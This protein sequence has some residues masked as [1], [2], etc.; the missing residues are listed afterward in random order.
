MRAIA[1]GAPCSVTQ[2]LPAASAAMPVGLLVDRGNSLTTPPVVMRATRPLPAA[3][4]NHRLPSPVTV[5]AV[6]LRSFEKPLATLPTYSVTAPPGVM[7]A[8]R[9]GLAGSA[10][11]SAPSGPA[12]MPAPGLLRPDRSLIVGAA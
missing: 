11:H 4:V 10:I 3:S 1:P 12:A 6:G 9:P 7:R 2:T 5:M 8:I